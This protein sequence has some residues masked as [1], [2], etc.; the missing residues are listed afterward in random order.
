MEVTVFVDV[1]GNGLLAS[2]EL[3]ECK[4]LKRQS[5]VKKDPLYNIIV[6]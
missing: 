3:S 5:D 4:K 1:R 2:R 6:I